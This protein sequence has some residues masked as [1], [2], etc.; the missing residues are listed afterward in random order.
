MKKI[1]PTFF[2]MLFLV[3]L[4]CNKNSIDR[5]SYPNDFYLKFSQN[6][7]SVLLM[8]TNVVQI[9]NNKSLTCTIGKN[10]EANTEF[11][12]IKYPSGTSKL[13]GDFLKTLIGVKLPFAATDTIYP[14]KYTTTIGFNIGGKNYTTLTPHK[15]NKSGTY[16]ITIQ[17]VELFK[18]VVLSPTKTVGYYDV[19]GKFSGYASTD[20]A[21]PIYIPSGIFR[22]LLQEYK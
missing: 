1:K 22:V 12:S 8:D 3:F 18:T 20:G 19:S 11:L 2:L 9:S 4:G 16:G 17:K 5:L 15:T 14:S 13:S 7:S 21:D 10:G 6:G